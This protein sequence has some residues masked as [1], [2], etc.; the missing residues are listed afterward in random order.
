MGKEYWMQAVDQQGYLSCLMISK[1]DAIDPLL[2]KYLQTLQHFQSENYPNVAFSNQPL[3][4]LSAQEQYDWVFCMNVI[5]HVADLELSLKRLVSSLKKDGKIVLSV[6]V[7]KYQ[8]LE[9]IFQILPGDILHPHQYTLDKY[10]ERIESTNIQI[11]Q[12]IRLKSGNIF[13]YYMI[14]GRKIL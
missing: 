14:V 1:V 11:E 6:D 12:K 8:W 4:A 9:K 5:N 2:N 10:L 13:D 7:H 3:E